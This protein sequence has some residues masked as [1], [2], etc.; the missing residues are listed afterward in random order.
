MK[1]KSFIFIILLNLLLV[2]CMFDMIYSAD[3]PNPHNPPANGLSIA[4]G[5]SPSST[6]IYQRKSCAGN[7]P[8]TF[9]S[10]PCESMCEC[11]GVVV[12]LICPPDPFPQY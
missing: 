2:F 1:K 5:Y 6:C 8:C 12:S 9:N 10:W 3:D 4:C 11:S 7:L